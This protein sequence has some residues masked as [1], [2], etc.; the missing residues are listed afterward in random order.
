MRSQSTHPQCV[1]VASSIISSNTRP[2]RGFRSL[3]PLPLA[4]FAS[5][6]F[7]DAPSFFSKRAF[8]AASGTRS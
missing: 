3:S 4:N 5:T 7:A 8:S 2:Y 6:C 1:Y